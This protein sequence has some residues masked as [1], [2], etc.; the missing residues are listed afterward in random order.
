MSNTKET[1]SHPIDRVASHPIDRLDVPV[2]APERNVLAGRSGRETNGRYAKGVAQPDRD[3]TKA[4]RALLKSAKRRDAKGTKRLDQMAD[5]VMDMAIA[6]NMQAIVFITEKL[7]GKATQ[8]IA[9]DQNITVSSIGEAHLH[10]LQRLT[11]AVTRHDEAKTLDTDAVT[12]L[13]T[14]DT[15]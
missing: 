9:I 14:Q 5:K 6:G 1:S 8:P 12:T 10:A 7:D 15:D 11:D 3:W 4:R 13:D 2:P